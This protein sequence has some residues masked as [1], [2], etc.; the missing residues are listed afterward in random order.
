MTGPE[1]IRICLPDPNG[2]TIFTG[3]TQE[4]VTKPEGLKNKQL[5]PERRSLP[6][7]RVDALTLGP[8]LLKLPLG[9]GLCFPHVQ[10]SSI[11]VGF[12]GEGGI[13]SLCLP[14]EIMEIHLYP[15]LS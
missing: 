13:M 12:E 5:Q 4:L 14:K 10:I 8:C 15:E 2:P 11:Q 9:M 7:V 6:Q 3:E 1:R